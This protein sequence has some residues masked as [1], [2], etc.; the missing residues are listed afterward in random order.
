[1]SSL[2]IGS[3]GFVGSNLTKQLNIDKFASSKNINSF[4]NKSFDVAYIAAG[5]ARKWIANGN[6]SQDRDHINKLYKDIS[7]INIKKIIHFSTIDVYMN[8]AGYEGPS[9]MDISEEAYGANRFALEGKLR[10]LCEEY[11]LIRLP[12]LFGPGL[13]KNII[14]DIKVGKDISN[15]NLNS[16]FQWFDLLDL[17]A[18]IDFVTKNNIFELN[19]CSEP[20]SVKE[21]LYSL[22]LPEDQCISGELGIVNYDIKSLHS[23]KFSNFKDYFY[24]KKDILSKINSFYDQ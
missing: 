6:P 15:F 2:L 21:L 1:M 13:K 24:T 19:V 20:L 9:L 18:V 3:T 10:G 5:D 14:Y 7:Q 12:G 8:K 4:K 17:S 16:N 11:Y 22:N 23:N